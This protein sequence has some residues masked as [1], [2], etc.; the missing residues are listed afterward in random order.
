MRLFGRLQPAVIAALAVIG[1]ASGA[2]IPVAPQLGFGAQAAACETLGSCRTS[3]A[4]T[5]ACAVNTN[6]IVSGQTS[7]PVY[8]EQTGGK[9]LRYFADGTAA[10]TG[11]SGDGLQLHRFSTARGALRWLVGRNQ[12]ELQA[13]DRVWG[14]GVSGPTHAVFQALDKVGLGSQTQSSDTSDVAR[15]DDGNVVVSERRDGGYTAVQAVEFP[16]AAGARLTGL[17]QWVGIDHHVVISTG[18]GEDGAPVSLTLYGP[19]REGWDLRV[20]TGTSPSV[21][22]MNAEDIDGRRFAMRSY[23]LD[24]TVEKNVRAFEAAMP[25]VRSVGGQRFR[26]LPNR[27]YRAAESARK[28]R[29]RFA[30]DL[31]ARQLRSEAV[32]VET[33]YNN[34]GG[35]PLTVQDTLV[36]ATGVPTQA[37]AEKFNPRLK[38]GQ[39]MDLKR[40]E[41]S[42]EP[43]VNCEPDDGSV[44]EAK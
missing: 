26:A 13:A 37:G 43:F 1:I 32:L 10:V 7:T 33:E 3:E 21:G 44:D 17:A 15:S 38:K 6:A 31:L 14:P 23:T 5:N 8:Y 41:D 27:E 36:L 16:H 11:D 22:K 4:M 39:A 9:G 28:D 25:G 30:T 19:A 2:I 40:P 34:P 12:A 18:Y 24:L 42:I 20:L 29:P 35:G